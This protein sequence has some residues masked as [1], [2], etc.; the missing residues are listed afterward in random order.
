M[1]VETVMRKNRISLVILLI[2]SMGYA[3][4]GGD[5]IIKKSTIASGGGFSN[6][7]DFA[8]N[9]SIGQTDASNSLNGEGYSLIG[10]FWSNTVNTDIIFKNSFE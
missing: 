10:G 7:G 9:G 2:F 1:S 5:F 4:N 8:L 6:G 3:Q